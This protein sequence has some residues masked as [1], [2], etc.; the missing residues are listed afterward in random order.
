MTLAS[1]VLLA[2]KTS[3]AL[4]VF[5]LGLNSTLLDATHLFHRPKDLA[6]AFLSM[7][8]VMPVF[9]ALMVSSFAL[10]PALK[11]ALVALSVAP[12]PPV[13]PN[14]ALKAGGRGS[15]TIGLLVAM[16]LLAI[17]VVPTVLQILQRV[18]KVPIGM[19][20]SSVGLIVVATVLGPLVAG[21]CIHRIAPGFAL[22]FANPL[23]LLSTV[24]LVVGAL[25]IL[26]TTFSSFGLLVGNGTIATRVAFV[27]VGLAT[28]H[29]LG[30]PNPE[31][32]PVLALATAS[33]HPGIAIAIAQ[34]N[35]PQQKLAMT[36]VILYL[37]VNA[38]VAI[39]YLRWIKRTSDIS[40]P[41]AERQ[42][43][44]SNT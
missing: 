32:R 6:K 29:L 41:A 38:I 31:D 25:P 23:G 33:R 44:R 13:L 17:V 9:A 27:V 3:I 14:K 28:G 35:F 16:S 1:V 2:L 10:H 30:G 24:M 18:F 8:V 22:R 5:A 15:Y 34:T 26:I 42:P 7:N 37:L 4:N 20:V 39:P 43:I 40:K 36:A 21:I 19:S 11:I 12:I